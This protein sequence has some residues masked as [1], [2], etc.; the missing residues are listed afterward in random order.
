MQSKILIYVTA[1]DSLLVPP[2]CIPTGVELSADHTVHFQP[3]VLSTQRDIRTES[4]EVLASSITKYLESELALVTGNYNLYLGKATF[5]L[6]PVSTELF[7]LAR[8][9][10]KDLNLL[11]IK[12][13]GWPAM[14]VSKLSMLTGVNYFI[15]RYFE[16]KNVLNLI[17][18]QESKQAAC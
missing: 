8:I 15:D 4:I 10:I 3:L 2:M 16:L 6:A 17:S 1:G 18:I 7:Q 5:S 11:D 13:R 12:F 14:S 9:D